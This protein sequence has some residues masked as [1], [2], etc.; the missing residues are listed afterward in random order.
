MNPADDTAYTKPV[1][2]ALARFA[3]RFTETMP[4]DAAVAWVHATA[5]VAWAE[6]HGLTGPWLRKNAEDQ[7]EEWLRVTGETHVGWQ[8]RA[9]AALCVHPGTWDLLNPLWTPLNGAPP[10]PREAARDLTA[11]WSDEAPPL[12]YDA[13]SGPGSLSGWVPG[14][15]LQHLSARRRE[16]RALVQTP[17]WVCD[18]IIDRTLLPALGDLRPVPV[19]AIDPAC[20]TGHF[21][22]R[23][24]GVLWEWYTTGAATPL[25]RAG[26]PV[27]GG[28]VLPPEQAAAAILQGLH[29]TD[30]DPLTAAVA[31]I[32]YTV[33]LGDLMRR[34]GLTA[35]PLRLDR[36]PQFQVPVVPADSLLAGAIP[37]E[38]YA[39]LHPDLAA[40]A[41]FSPAVADD[42]V[43]VREDRALRAAAEAAWDQPGLFGDGDAA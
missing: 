14:D 36:I 33:T 43:V 17:W 12:A 35:G 41:P 32:R 7:R 1:A 37:G 22:V 25:T 8:A 42:T 3:D 15:L 30:R 5:L 11:W 21:L 23:M 31:R 24:I 18:F 26:K 34:S 9:T 4:E 39:A 6:D 27:S 2:K 19:R 16:T 13:D 40:I 29:G 20:G 10:P 28:P 38:E